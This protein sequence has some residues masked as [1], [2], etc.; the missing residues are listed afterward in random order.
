MRG[1]GANHLPDNT[2]YDDVLQGSTCA[3]EVLNA[4]LLAA[5]IIATSAGLPFMLSGEEFARTKYGDDNSFD[6]GSRINELDWQRASDMQ[7]LVRYYADLIAMRADDPAWFDAARTVVP[8]ESSMIAFLVGRHAVLV[9]PDVR[10]HVMP[11]TVMNR[12]VAQCG[13]DTESVS[14]LWRCM[15]D[16]TSD[17]YAISGW[18]DAQALSLI[19]I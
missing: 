9:N 3:Q 13:G 11:L 18:C 8:T 2:M 5:G 15:L 12:T 1:N 17:R 7:G 16:S 4:N 14:P 6:S 19:H 10:E